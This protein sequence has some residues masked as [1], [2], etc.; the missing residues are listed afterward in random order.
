MNNTKV[1]SLKST[2]AADI[3]ASTDFLL[4]SKNEYTQNE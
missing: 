1:I 4:I 2:T 3:F